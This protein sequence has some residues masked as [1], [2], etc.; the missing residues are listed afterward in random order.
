MIVMLA[1]RFVLRLLP[2]AI[3]VALLS[4]PA[5]ATPLGLN[6]GDIVSVLEWDADRINVPGDG[7]SFTTTGTNTG[8]T[9][10]D[11][12]ITSVQIQG[13]TTNPLTGV[14]FQLN[15][16]LSAV[17]IIPLGGTTVL[18]SLTFV[19]VT[20]DDITITDGTGTILT[21]ELA[22]SGLTV[23]GVFDTSGALIDPTAV[24]N[25]VDIAI[26]GGDASLVAALGT[27][28]TLDLNGT[29]F[30][31]LPGADV[32]LADFLVNENFVYSGSG[33]MSP[34]NPAAFPEPGA[35]LL[36]ALALGGIVLAR[37]RNG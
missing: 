12:R 25:A 5:E 19:G 7:G 27:T 28:G 30:D 36:M 2:V 4:G 35:S 1:S 16:S 22:A 21:A 34:T 3:V 18:A 24:A 33:T 20:G 23:G 37:R 6:P 11:G 8:D 14:N 13:P 29:L 17:S 26:T 32:I 31:F 9:T 10:M 15:A